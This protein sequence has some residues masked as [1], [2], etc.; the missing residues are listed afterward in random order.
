M[1]TITTEDVT[2]WMREQLN[3]AHEIGDYAAIR[4][5]LTQFKTGDSK[6]RYNIYCSESHVSRDKSTIEECFVELHGQTPQTRAEKLRADASE[7]L[8]QADGLDAFTQI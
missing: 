4:V 3:K 6:V 7:L 5:E 1:K 2:N 8:K